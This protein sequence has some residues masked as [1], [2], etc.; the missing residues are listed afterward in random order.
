MLTT[1]VKLNLVECS[2]VHTLNL[3]KRKKKNIVLD[4]Q[5]DNCRL[6]ITYKVFEGANL[7]LEVV[8]RHFVVFDNTRDLELANAVTDR[9]QLG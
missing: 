4:S 1:F 3:K 6:E 2:N 7:V 5:R 9:H 8:G